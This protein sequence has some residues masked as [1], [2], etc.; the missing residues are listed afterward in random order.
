MSAE[1]ERELALAENKLQDAHVDH[2]D[3]DLD[4]TLVIQSSLHSP[5]GSLIQRTYN[6]LEWIFLAHK[7]SKTLKTYIEKVSELTLKGKLRLCQ[8]AGI[9]PSKIIVPFY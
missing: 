6:T 7:Q 4:Y 9:D 8:L 1:A 2:L 3:P 5:I